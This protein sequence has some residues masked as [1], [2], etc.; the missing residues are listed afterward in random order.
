MNPFFS[1]SFTN[2]WISHF[3]NNEKPIV[4]KSIESVKFLHT[5]RKLFYFN[6]GKNIT[7]GVS[8][9]LR[10]NQNDCKG[11]VFIIYDVLPYLRE[12]Q[13][14]TEDHSYLKLIKVPQ[15]KGYLTNLSG[16]KNFDDYFSQ[17]YS[18][19]SRSNIRKWD[20]RLGE[21]FKIRFKVFYGTIE[22]QEYNYIFDNLLI[23]IQK[24]WN[25][26]GMENDILRDHVYYRELCYNMI[27]D[28]T[29]S[30][31]VVY[32]NEEIVAL[33][34]CFSSKKELFFAITTFDIDFR[35]YNLGHLLI[36]YIMKWCFENEFEIF[37]Y[38]KG[39]YEYK[40]RWSNRTYAFEHHILYDRTTVVSLL[41]GNSLGFFYKMK[42]FL[43]DKNINLLYSRIK[44]WVHTLKLNPKKEP[45]ILI[46]DLDS[47]DD[48]ITKSKR[49]YKGSDDYFKLKPIICDIIFTFTQPFDTVKAYKVNEEKNKFV[50]VGDD[51]I[52]EVVFESR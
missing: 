34:F 32:A 25:D 24:R 26:L 11:K 35:K 6:V 43:R 5:K 10:N 20:R 15:Y 27:I 39:T 30:M 38:S 40:T 19:K 52:K 50:L 2:I 36:M 3:G 37:D 13:N 4:F 8:Y 18:T 33:S 9:I 41:V 1:K 47:A 29:G 51:F 49:V 44:Y 48:V 42:Q 7:N 23:L 14:F 45:K 28:K 22:L 12:R 16:Y 21:N 31:N 17:H 46:K